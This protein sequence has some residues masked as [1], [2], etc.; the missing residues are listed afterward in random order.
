MESGQPLCPA[1]VEGV[2]E[3]GPQ[4]LESLLT[5]SDLPPISCWESANSQEQNWASSMEQ[6]P[7]EI[8]HLAGGRLITLDS[9]IMEKTIWNRH[10]LWTQTCLHCTQNFLQNALYEAGQKDRK[11]YGHGSEMWEKK[12]P[13]SLIWLFVLLTQ[14]GNPSDKAKIVCRDNIMFSL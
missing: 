1:M 10:H 4:Q 6:F 11:N 14:S 8:C 2:G 13:S 7:R 5:N 12:F 3:T 9:P